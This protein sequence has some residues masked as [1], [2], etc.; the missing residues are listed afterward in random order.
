MTQKSI[1]VVEDDPVLRYDAVTMLETAGLQVAE[2][3][4]ADDALAYTFERSSELAA[5]FT[6]VQL[7]GICDGL[8]L[9]EIVSRHW[10]HIFVLLCSGR[11]RPATALPR[12]VRF[13][14]KPWVP[15]TVLTALQDAAA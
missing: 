5:I 3:D 11:V 6:D 15:L 8:H 4:N 12:N 13:M 1:L 9:A 10:P 14:Q 7:P 2:M